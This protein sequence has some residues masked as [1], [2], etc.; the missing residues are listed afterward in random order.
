MPGFC[1][2]LMFTLWLFCAQ[3]RAAAILPARETSTM[4]Y[5]VIWNEILL[6]LIN[7]CIN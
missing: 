3:R 1:K 2:R 6:E 5:S 7:K 4:E